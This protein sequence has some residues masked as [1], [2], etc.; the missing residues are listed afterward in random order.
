MIAPF[1]A[2]LFLLNIKFCKKDAVVSV[3]V[4]PSSSAGALCWLESENSGFP[5]A[6]VNFLALV[7]LFLLLLSFASCA[8]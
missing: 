4:A 2:K 1:A 3:A 8:P 6:N 7:E 5:S